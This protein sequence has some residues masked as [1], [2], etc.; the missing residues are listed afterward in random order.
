ME[1]L[2]LPLDQIIHTDCVEGMKSLP[3]DCIDLIVTSPPYGNLRTYDGPPYTSELFQ[4]VAKELT[5]ITKHRGVICWVV[6]NQIVKGSENCQAEREKLFFVNELSLKSHQTIILVPA[7]SPPTDVSHK[8]YANNFDYIYV[9]CKGDSPEYVYLHKDRRNTNVGAATKSRQ[10]RNAKGEIKNSGSHEYI[11]KE[12][13]YRT[14]VWNFALGYGRTTKDYHIVN[15][16]ALMPEKLAEDL[17]TSFSKTD[18]L[19]F[20]PFAGGGTT[21]KL[22]M[23][24]HRRYLGMER[25]AKYVEMARKRLIHAETHDRVERINRFLSSFKP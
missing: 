22:A 20:D 9:F 1:Y 14:N 11:V 6:R 17:I 25:D 21:L 13:G 3:D 23:L 19:V 8:R 15:H 12:W 7:G 24:N 16:P 10:H 2:E 18:Q 4:Q 5:R